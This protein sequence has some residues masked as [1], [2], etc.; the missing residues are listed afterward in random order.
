MKSI[1]VLL[2]TAITIALLALLSIFYPAEGITVGNITLR[3]PSLMKILVKEEPIDIE[4]LLQQEEQGRQL[5]SMR[6]SVDYYRAYLDSSD[7]RF[8]LPNNDPTYFDDLFEQLEKAKGEGRT[9]RI[10]HYGDSQIEMD[11]MTPQ[12]RAY[13]QQT[14]GGGGPGLLCI[15]PVVGSQTITQYCSG[16]LSHQ[17][18]FILD[19]ETHSA[20][21]NYGPMAHCWS[22]S[23][24]A[25]GGVNA[26]KD[27]KVDDR[28][29]QFSTITLL[30]NNRNGVMNATISSK[31]IDFREAQSYA[32][33]G[34]HTLRWTLP[35][36]VSSIHYSL[37][38]QGDIYGIMV[39][40]GPGV[41]VDNIAMRGCS[42]QQFSLI[43][44]DQLE[45]AYA[46]MDVAL[47]ILQ[48]GGNSV[49]YLRPGKSLNSYCNSLT[50][51]IKHLRKVCPTAKFLFVG[52]SDMSTT[53]DGEIRSYPSM[54][55]IVDSLREW[56]LRNDIAYWSIYD[57][58]GGYNTMK[59]W[60]DN[61]LAN[62]DYIH[63]STKGVKIMGDRF[64]EAF[65]RMYAF[66]Q[67][68]RRI[69]STQFDSI[70]NKRYHFDS[71]LLMQDSLQ[72]TLAQEQEK[73][74]NND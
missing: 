15:R 60:V 24:G 40:D 46:E 53:I 22:L 50:Q 43:N 59:A 27:G 25:N 58:M 12:L 62:T 64:V 48:F 21:G 72:R 36:S 5:L 41:A 4:A 11:R 68:R 14:F 73:K 31:E 65:R 33:S 47:I 28:C 32:E 20:N 35:Q 9:V 69:P 7:L 56:A 70:W 74:V 19:E 44:A 17:S 61:G 37:Q 34:V 2:F 57:A 26:S 71:I 30:F 66:Y 49:P 38:G 23:G 16:S 63:F 18:S 52:P 6:D 10:L 13:M 39:D 55:I 29:K 42:G 1:K 3:F 8:S 54:P 51:Q 67:L 45:A